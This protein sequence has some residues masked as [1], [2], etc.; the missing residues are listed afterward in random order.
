MGEGRRGRPCI[1]CM[2]CYHNVFSYR[3]IK[4]T[5]PKINYF[6]IAGTVL[7]YI[8]VYF[9]FPAFTSGAAQAGCLVKM[10]WLFYRC[11]SNSIYAGSRVAIYSWVYAYIR[12]STFQVMESLHNFSK[13]GP[14]KEGKLYCYDG[15]VAIKYTLLC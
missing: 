7:M 2:Y 11:F 13:S 3:I 9:Y 1:Q 4:L 5:S 8:S 6:I 10:I 14:K 15:C 12:R